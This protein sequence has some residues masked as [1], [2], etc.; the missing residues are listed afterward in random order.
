MSLRSFR[1]VVC[2]GSTAIRPR[3]P[4]NHLLATQSTH[5]A[6]AQPTAKTARAWG[7]DGGFRPRYGGGLGPRAA[8]AVV[9]FLWPVTQSRRGVPIH[10]WRADGVELLII[11]KSAKFIAGLFHDILV[12]FQP[13]YNGASFGWLFV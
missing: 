1:H 2:L 11:T 8:P 13:R 3:S 6:A 10:P 7:S 9:I 5:C 4:D 12:Y